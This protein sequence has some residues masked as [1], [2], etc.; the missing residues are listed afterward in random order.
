MLDRRKSALGF[1]THGAAEGG[2]RDAILVGVG[3]WGTLEFLSAT[4]GA[5]LLYP[6]RRCGPVAG[7]DLEEYGS[8][9]QV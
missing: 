6:E 1:A 7:R 8:A 2:R 9:T 4:I 3:G 5:L